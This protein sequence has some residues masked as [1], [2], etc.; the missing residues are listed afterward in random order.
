[1]LSSR[2]PESRNTL[3][4]LLRVCHILLSVVN[5]VAWAPHELGAV[6]ACASSDGKCSVLTLKDDGTW[7]SA[8]FDAHTLGCNAISWASSAAPGSLNSAS[9]GTTPLPVRKIATA[10]NDG[11]VKIWNFMADSQMWVVEAALEGHTD[12]VRD[13]AF[14]PNVG[15]EKAM[16]A[17]CGH[18]KR[19]L[20]WTKDEP[21]A[22]GW[23]KQ[24]LN[25]GEFKETVWRVSWSLAG[26]VLAVSCGD[27]KVTL[28]RETLDNSWECA[29]TVDEKTMFAAPSN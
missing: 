9:T 20:I 8:M 7:D 21:G 15:T 2:G 28:W 11:L 29:N 12:W 16:L 26:G 10:G 6:L 14:A 18:D 4:T 1:M 3:P 13:V 22:A 17:S 25:E 23:H 5:S 24:E 27:N 19:V